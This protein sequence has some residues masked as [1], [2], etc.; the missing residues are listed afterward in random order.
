VTLAPAQFPPPARLP[1][2]FQLG[3]WRLQTPTALR[4]RIKELGA[5]KYIIKGMLPSRSIGLL[6]GDSGLGKSPLMYQAAICVAA[7][8][9]FLGRPT[10][11]GNV[12]IFPV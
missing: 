6:L 2:P 12:I 8:L 1:T 11:K 5:D 3:K 4:E 10:T 9:P 7:G